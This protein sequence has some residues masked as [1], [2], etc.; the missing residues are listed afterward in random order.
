MDRRRILM[1]DLVAAPGMQP[2]A[3]RETMEVIKAIQNRAVL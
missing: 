1:G 3:S 2:R